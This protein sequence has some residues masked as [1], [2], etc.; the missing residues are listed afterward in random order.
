MFNIT[1]VSSV[2]EEVAR[3]SWPPTPSESS[4][5]EESSWEILNRNSYQSFLKRH[6][7]KQNYGK[8]QKQQETVVNYH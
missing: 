2:I 1:P 3:N 5:V 8:E 7:F 6:W 4:I